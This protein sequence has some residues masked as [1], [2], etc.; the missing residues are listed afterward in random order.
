L[1][2]AGCSKK[3]SPGDPIWRRLPAIDKTP[4]VA[5]RP[6]AL[7]RRGLPEYQHSSGVQA[8]NALVST[9]WKHGEILVETRG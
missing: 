9:R 3:S 7:S 8:T 1:A 2:K 6:M 4:K 5:N